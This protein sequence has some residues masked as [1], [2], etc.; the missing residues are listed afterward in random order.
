MKKKR[1]IRWK[2]SEAQKEYL[3]KCPQAIYN[4]A[5]G[6]VRSG[7]TVCNILAFARELETTPDRLHLATGLT[8]SAAK[9]NLGDCNGYGLEHLFRGRCRWGRYH[10]NPAL[11]IQTR[12]GQKIVLFAGGGKAD[13]YK[14]IRGNSYG[15]WIATEVNKHYLSDD[16]ASFVQEAFNRQLAAKNRKVFWDLN[17]DYPRH[18]IYTKYIDRFREDGL[19]VNYRHFTIYDNPSVSREQLEQILL[20]YPPGSIWHR[21][22][23]LGERCAAEGL[24]FP[25]FTEHPEQWIVDRPPEDLAFVTVGCDYGGTNSRTVFTA[26]GIRK[27]YRGICVLACRRLVGGKGKITPGALEREFVDFVYS[28]EAKFHQRPQYA[29]MDSE[30]QYLTNGI[31]AA[32]AGAGLSISVCD[33]KKAK[34]NDRIACKMRLISERRWSVMKDC[35]E[36]IRSTAEQVWDPEEPDRRLDNGTTDVDTA[37]AEEYAWSPWM[38]CF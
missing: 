17:P 37:D 29:F 12:T 5:E 32:C 16:D 3:G 8:L 31:R 9:L 25:E 30:A 2:F 6:A 28:L 23:I 34:I 11:F 26:V 35:E 22:W 18:P 14:R 4:F 20:Q 24:I 36:V 19:A 21:R 13:S 7:K 33:C 10:D 38:N 27:E 15:M 1:S